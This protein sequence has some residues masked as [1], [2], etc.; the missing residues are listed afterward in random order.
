[1]THFR[2]GVLALLMFCVFGAQLPAQKI[3]G[4]PPSD[5]A[6]LREQIGLGQVTLIFGGGERVRGQITDATDRDITLD[7]TKRFLKEQVVEVEAK[8]RDPV[9]NGMLVGMIVGSAA[10]FTALYLRHD[11]GA[12][13]FLDIG[14]ALFGAVAGLIGGGFVDRRIN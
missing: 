7:N 10:G 8:A 4:G 1:M 11:R 13:H 9:N 12:P 2:N 5:W 6:V 3:I 14:G